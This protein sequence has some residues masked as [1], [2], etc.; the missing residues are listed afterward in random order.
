MS[1]FI[2]PEHKTLPQLWEAIQV[3]PVKKSPNEGALLMAAPE[4][5]EFT[6]FPQ[7]NH[8]P[9]SSQLRQCCRQ[10]QKIP[11]LK[12][13]QSRSCSKNEPFPHPAPVLKLSQNFL[14]LL[15]PHI[16]QTSLSSTESLRPEEIQCSARRRENAAAE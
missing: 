3:H 8:C 11:D 2:T 4:F 12:P 1:V 13:A 5:T 10:P 7:H 14:A 15:S 16:C 9:A 6:E